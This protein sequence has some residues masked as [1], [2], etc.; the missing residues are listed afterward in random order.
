MNKKTIIPSVNFHLWQP[1]NMRCGFCFAK[2][3]DVKSSILPKGHLPKDKAQKTIKL[4]ADYGFEKITFVGGEP[5]LCPWLSELIKYAKLLGMTTMIVSN[6]TNLT[7]GFL[8]ENQDFLDWVSISVDSLKE[9]TNYNIGRTIKRKGVAIEFYQ[10]LFNLIKKYDYRLKIN[11]VVNSYNYKE[12]LSKFIINV[13]PERWKVFKVLP[14]IDQ[15][16]QEYNKFKISGVKFKMFLE[17]HKMI[18]SLVKENNNDMIGSY[19][20][21]DPAGRFFDN[22]KGYYSYSSPI[23][24][25]GVEKALNEVN[26]DYEK[27]V[28][29]KGIYK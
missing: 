1:C 20:M 3:Q 29:R 24:E 6:G 19:V 16:H 22:T 27:F 18:S 2:F 12:D 14:I 11:T 4:L 8:K 7:E 23:I 21:V 25:N 28:N 13:K 26:T 17:T 10:N 15:N 5:I 9:A